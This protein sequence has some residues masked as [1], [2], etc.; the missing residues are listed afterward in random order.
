[1]KAKTVTTTIK[2]ANRLGRD[3]SVVLEPLGEQF[4]L[5]AGT[6]MAISTEVSIKTELEIDVREDRL[7]LWMLDGPDYDKTLAVTVD[8]KRM[9]R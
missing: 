8:G 7:S 9:T 6:T 3:H 5:P 4:V 2:I 1:M